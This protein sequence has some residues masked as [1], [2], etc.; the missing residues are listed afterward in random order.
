MLTGQLLFVKFPFI[1]LLKKVLPISL[2]FPDAFWES[3]LMSPS[4]SLNHSLVVMECLILGI[5]YESAPLGAF[6]PS[7]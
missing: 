4:S 3:S 6:I 1:Y 5:K 7:R 2:S